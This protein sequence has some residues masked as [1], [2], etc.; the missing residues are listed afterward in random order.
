MAGRTFDPFIAQF[1]VSASGASVGTVSYNPVELGRLKCCLLSE[2]IM[3]SGTPESQPSLSNSFLSPPFEAAA[4]HTMWQEDKITQHKW[5]A[6][7][8]NL[9]S[10]LERLLGQRAAWKSMS[11]VAHAI[12]YLSASQPRQRFAPVIVPEKRASRNESTLGWFCVLESNLFG[13]NIRLRAMDFSLRH[14]HGKLFH[15]SGN[16]ITVATSV[17]FS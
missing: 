4:S 16:L 10:G 6:G 14:A 12:T 15:T 2:P 5:F 7:R 9:E 13:S 1:L 17:Y 3:N 11:E 8:N